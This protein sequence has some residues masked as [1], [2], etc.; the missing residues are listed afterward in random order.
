MIRITNKSSLIERAI[1][2]PWGNRKSQERG[3]GGLNYRVAE[4]L[5]MI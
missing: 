4:A 3:K 2:V 1:S 5:K